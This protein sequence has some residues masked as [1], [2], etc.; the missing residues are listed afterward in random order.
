MFRNYLTVALRTLGRQRAYAAINLLG[1]AVGLTC[2]AL[3][4][5]F[6]RHEQSYDRHFPAA[7]Q[8]YQVHTKYRASWYSVVGFDRYFQTPAEDQLRQIEAIRD[9]P[10]VEQAA[11][12]M[13]FSEPQ[14]IEVDGE[15]FVE[16]SLLTTNTGAAWL[17]L[18]APTFVQGEALSALD[19]PFTAVI[20]EAVAERY[21]GEAEAVGQTIRLDTLDLTVTG[22]VEPLPAT[23]HFTFDLAVNLPRIGYWG[24]YT[25]ARLAPGA[26][27][28]DAETAVEGAIR[29]SNP[30]L[31]ESPLFEATRL[32]PVTALHYN[33]DALYPL[34]PPSQP[35]Y[36]FL[37]GSVGLL[38][39]LITLTNYVNLSLA[40]YTTRQQ[41][42]AVRKALGAER[43]SLISQF[44]IEAT[45]LASCSMLLALGLVELILPF[46]D[47]TMGTAIA[48]SAG[49]LEVAALLCGLALITGLAAGAYPAFWL[50]RRQALALF[51]KQGRAGRPAR[52]DLRRVLIT[53]QFAL[54]IGLG[55]LT[56]F[57]QHQLRYVQDKDLGFAYE[58]VISINGVGGGENYARLKGQLEGVPGI[59][60]VGMG[61]TPGPSFNQ[62]TYRAPDSDV[63]F[64]DANWTYV[65]F[66][67]FDVLQIDSPF[68]DD[69]RNRP[70]PESGFFVVNDATAQRLGYD[71]PVG[72]TVILEPEFEGG[73]EEQIAGV[74]DDLHMF[75][76]HEAVRPLLINVQPEPS[77]A[78][79]ALV[80][81]DTPDRAATMAEIEAI[82]AEV[83]PDQ[84][85]EVT[86]VDETLRTL[87]EEDQRIATLT[88]VLTGLA[89][90][91]A[92]L[93]LV[94][95]AAYMTNRRRKEI[96]VRKVLGASVGSIL[97]LLNREFVG[98]VG[99]GLVIAAP[100]AYLVSRAWLDTFAYRVDLNVWVFPAVA[101]GALLLTLLAV[102]TQTLHAAHVNPAE[103]LRDD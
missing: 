47:A 50:A 38:V 10:A 90:V 101:V 64:D 60:A 22:V 49:R 56:W 78:F 26:A 19:R 2:A 95:L 30:R 76:L 5:L 94:G 75:S 41:E 88:L 82:W 15:R 45:L 40:L 52:V 59:A 18:F 23:S 3:V 1:L 83:R 39:L 99:A 58:G 87:Y 71:D 31:A 85:L 48:A 96:S 6:L 32:L 84:P 77:W 24:G 14:F 63:V 13:Y 16:E 97:G 25:Y 61:L 17:D 55:S 70:A 43:N 51:R 28:D 68:L 42:V 92:I 73:T 36:I 12:F 69:F 79:S 44:L 20:T 91:M 27:P 103:T 74:V 46:F 100:L 53:G 11:H 37:I 67:W 81:L 66:G 57:I 72:Q 33:D 80:R 8:L 102:G 7:E 9:V 93:G 21:F 65:D 89:V 35:A 98:L 54:L 34:K 29:A 86:Y 62:V 4:V